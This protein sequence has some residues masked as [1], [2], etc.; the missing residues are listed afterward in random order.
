MQRAK[1][2]VLGFALLASHGRV[3]LVAFAGSA[4]IQCPLTFD[5]GGL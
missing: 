2:A 4:F 3:G 1:F 5:D